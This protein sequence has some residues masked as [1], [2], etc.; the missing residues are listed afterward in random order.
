M[1]REFVNT[2]RG[3]RRSIQ[4]TTYADDTTFITNDATIS[5][6]SNNEPK[7]NS[8]TKSN[9]KSYSYT[10]Q[11]SKSKWDQ[12]LTNSKANSPHIKEQKFIEH[13]ESNIQ[14]PLTNYYKAEIEANQRSKERLI[15]EISS[16]GYQIATESEGSYNPNFDYFKLHLG[17]WIT[18]LSIETFHMEDAKIFLKSKSISKI[19]NDTFD[20]DLISFMIM[21]S[22]TST[23][24]K[25]ANEGY[26]F[27]ELISY[28]ITDLIQ[29]IPFLYDE[30][31]TF[32]P[33]VDIRGHKIL[34]VGW[35]S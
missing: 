16:P 5:S 13:S 2:T 25:E 3:R 19:T 24:L 8:S 14:L 26:K 10:N 20:M 7:S 11:Y 1:E 34:G 22:A 30:W 29:T 21:E 32:K 33:L 17:A 31:I 27:N 12:L 18:P 23:I 28:Q 35:R 9:S 6:T 4:T 15:Q